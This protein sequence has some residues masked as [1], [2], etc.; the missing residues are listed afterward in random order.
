MTSCKHLINRRKESMLNSGLG[1]TAAPPLTC[2]QH[3]RS[4]AILNSMAPCGEMQP[5]NR[6]NFA[7]LAM[8]R[9]FRQSMPEFRSL[10]AYYSNQYPG[11][12]SVD[13][14]CA[15]YCRKNEH[16]VDSSRNCGDYFYQL[17]MM[18]MVLQANKAKQTCNNV[19]STSVLCE[20]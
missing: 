4:M 12:D 6:Q 20:S 18:G 9:K 19:S 3:Y 16:P 8:K 14:R 17:E 11:C 2:N 1:A 13:L 5:K 7:D 15:D 10:E